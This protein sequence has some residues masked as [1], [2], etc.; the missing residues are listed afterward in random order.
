MQ[1]MEISITVVTRSS[2]THQF[3]HSKGYHSSCPSNTMATAR[4][5]R[6][7]TADSPIR[8]SP[9]SQC[10][11]TL[12]IKSNRP[13]AWADDC[14]ACLWIHTMNCKCE[15]LAIFLLTW[16]RDEATPKRT[17]RSNERSRSNNTH[18][19]NRRSPAWIGFDHCQ[20][21]NNT[22]FWNSAM[23]STASGLSCLF[24]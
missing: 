12:S 7:A 1:M 13:K 9:S 20:D 6:T 18:E 21:S 5:Y 3:Y 19:R 2:L 23:I 14:S 24:G 17:P 10:I 22:R 16:S 11:C 8:S 15:T 4:F